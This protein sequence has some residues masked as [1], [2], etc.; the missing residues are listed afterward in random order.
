M[1]LRREEEED[2]NTGKE[3]ECGTNRKTFVVKHH[4][5]DNSDNS[6]PDELRRAVETCCCPVDPRKTYA[7][8]HIECRVEA[9]GAA[10][11]VLH[12]GKSLLA[13]FCLI[14]T[15]LSMA[16][17]QEKTKYVKKSKMRMKNFVWREIYH[18]TS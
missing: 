12:Y 18:P 2:C 15:F 4:H 14:S 3:V 1:G 13:I 17:L 10:Q 9:L 5:E 6:E 8:P 16:F 11:V 7:I